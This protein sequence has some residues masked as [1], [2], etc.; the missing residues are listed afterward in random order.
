MDNVVSLVS[1]K[2]R[3][4]KETTE[5]IR[6]YNTGFISYFFEEISQEAINE[7]FLQYDRDTM[8]CLGLKEGVGFT[9]TPYVVTG[10]CPHDPVEEPFINFHSNLSMFK[11]I[12]PGANSFVNGIIPVPDDCSLPVVVDIYFYTDDHDYVT[13]S[14]PSTPTTFLK[15]ECGDLPHYFTLAITCMQLI[16]LG[17]GYVFKGTFMSTVD[18]KVYFKA[19]FS[20]GDSIAVVRYHH[21]TALAELKTYFKRIFPDEVIE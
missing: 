2:E 8:K 21:T 1:R 19:V 16:M 5:S 6:R 10:M 11:V 15:D 14:Y 18:G 3:I 13:D 17:R 12:E 4:S 9:P 7:I 20:K